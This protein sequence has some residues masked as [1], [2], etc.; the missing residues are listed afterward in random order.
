MVEAGEFAKRGFLVDLLEKG[1]QFL[2][3]DLG[4]DLPGATRE[5]CRRLSVLRLPIFTHFHMHLPS[6]I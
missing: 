3:G 2:L 5:S 6:K 4:G 1:F